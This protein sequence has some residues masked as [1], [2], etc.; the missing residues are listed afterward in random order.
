MYNRSFMVIIWRTCT[1]NCSHQKHFFE[2]KCMS[3]GGPAPPGPAE[4]AYSCRSQTLGCG[5]GREGAAG[6]TGKGKGGEEGEK[7][8]EERKEKRD[9]RGSAP[10]DYILS[11]YLLHCICMPSCLQACFC[12]T[13]VI[14]THKL[15]PWPIGLFAYERMR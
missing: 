14:H 4:K 6:N 1:K 3:F 11:S 9:R 13:T 12:I 7:G 10:T 2:P 15:L 8:E 5:P